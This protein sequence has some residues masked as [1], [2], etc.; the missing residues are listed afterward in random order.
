MI[1]HESCPPGVGEGA[2]YDAPQPDTG[3]AL[4][5]RQPGLAY[6][7]I[8]STFHLYYNE[9]FRLRLMCIT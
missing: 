5:L 3:L 7:V 4:L 2:A 1:C 6:V 8:S 9:G